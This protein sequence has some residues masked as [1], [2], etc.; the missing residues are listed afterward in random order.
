MRHLVLLLSI[1][2][3]TLS[4]PL[5]HASTSSGSGAVKGVRPTGPM[6]RPTTTRQVDKRIAINPQPLPPGSAAR[7]AI[8]PQ[9]LP[10]R[11]PP[12]DRE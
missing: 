10:P 2:L 7:S 9:P 4:A 8:N 3:L 11:N 5:V 6:I 1:P 12:T